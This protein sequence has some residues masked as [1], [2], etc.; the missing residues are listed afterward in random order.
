VDY[1]AFIDVDRVDGLLHLTEIA[2]HRPASPEECCIV[3]QQLEL[4]VL[5][6]EL[7]KRKLTLG[8]KQLTPHPWETFG[9][10]LVE[11]SDMDG[12]VTR[13]LDYGAFVELAPGV[14]AC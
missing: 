12:T 11:G 1:G 6:I 2:W 13:I 5:S 7:A 14:P 4:V 10:E 8:L 3:G 9:R